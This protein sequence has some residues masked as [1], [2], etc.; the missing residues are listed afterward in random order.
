MARSL[1]LLGGLGGCLA[2]C[3]AVRHGPFVRHERAAW[4]LLAA[5]PEQTLPTLSQGVEAGSTWVA[6]DGVAQPV[7]TREGALVLASPQGPGVLDVPR[8]A[9]DAP[10][11]VL[12]PMNWRA[13]D[14]LRGERRGNSVHLR[15]L[16]DDPELQ[17]TTL[18]FVEAGQD[19]AEL[20]VW[21]PFDRRAPCKEW[22]E[23]AAVLEVSQRGCFLEDHPDC[24]SERPLARQPDGLYR[25]GP[26][27]VSIE[28]VCSEVVFPER[29][30]A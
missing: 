12:K 2:G 11:L 13:A 8:G 23:R 30:G 7:F 3:L 1:I 28:A 22:G 5:L 10:G 29:E 21:I 24:A 18:R 17:S 15:F 6:L 25:V 4:F 9:L 14:I 26:V 16:T 20:I 19:E 27:L